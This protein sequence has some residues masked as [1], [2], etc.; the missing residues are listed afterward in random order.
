[1]LLFDPAFCVPQRYP[2]L[3]LHAYNTLSATVTAHLNAF[4]RVGRAAAARGNTHALDHYI[5]A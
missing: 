4:G 2:H 1:M 5:T 3:F